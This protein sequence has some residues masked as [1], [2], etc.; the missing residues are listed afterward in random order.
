MHFIVNGKCV[1]KYCCIF[2][3]NISILLYQIIYCIRSLA[4]DKSV[5]PTCASEIG[6]AWSKTV[7]VTTSLQVGVVREPS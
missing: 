6:T 3:I 5:M 2:L 4:D 1:F 7:H